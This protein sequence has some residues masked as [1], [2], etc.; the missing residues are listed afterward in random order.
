MVVHGGKDLNIE[1]MMKHVRMSSAYVWK[2]NSLTDVSKI[3]VLEWQTEATRHETTR[4]TWW[5]IGIMRTSWNFK[6]NGLT[7]SLWMAILH[8]HGGKI[9]LFL[10][11]HKNKN[12]RRS[13][14]GQWHGRDFIQLI[15]EY[16]NILYVKIDNYIIL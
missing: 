6:W 7:V 1:I 9:N 5:R 8:H 3:F 14:K 4:D 12:Q 13:W 15:M 2:L 16:L 11:S 10:W